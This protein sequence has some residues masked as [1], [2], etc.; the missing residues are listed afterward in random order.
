MAWARFGTGKWHDVETDWDEA[1]GLFVINLRF[2]VCIDAVWTFAVRSGHDGR[3][4]V[5]LGAAD[6]NARFA[7]VAVTA[8]P[9]PPSERARRDESSLLTL[10]PATPGPRTAMR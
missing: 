5:W 1:L 6:V 7:P 2:D 10:Q 8:P 4:T 9:P 3:D